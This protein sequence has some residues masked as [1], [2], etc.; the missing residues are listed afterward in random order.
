MSNRKG[1]ILKEYLLSLI[2]IMIFFPL[3]ISAARLISD[4]EYFDH[5]LQN[6]LSILKLRDKLI[7]ANIKSI[8]NF[9]VIYE[10]DNV[11]WLLKYDGIRLYLSPGY[12]LFLDNVDDLNFMIKDDLLYVNYYIDN[13]NYERYLKII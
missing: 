5:E 10:Q 3:I 13:K 8:D 7:T 4:V 12:Q 2:I 9:N 6:E 11:E 1:F